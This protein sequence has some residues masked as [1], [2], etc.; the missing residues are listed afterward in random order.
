VSLKTID[1]G[2]C[3]LLSREYEKEKEDKSTGI[4][5]IIPREF[6]ARFMRLHKRIQ[7]VFVRE[8]RSMLAN[9]ALAVDAYDFMARAAIFLQSALPARI[10]RSEIESRQFDNPPF[11]KPRARDLTFTSRHAARRR[12]DA[13][14][15]VCTRVRVPSDDI[16]TLSFAQ[17]KK[18]G[19]GDGR[20]SETPARA[21]E[22]SF[23]GCFPH[24]VQSRGRRRGEKGSY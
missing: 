12:R 2:L 7:C 3:S 13:I 17:G 1:W 21:G 4:L 6:L 20:S 11:K 5:H 19:K 23:R 9:V 10:S 14:L 18:D 24:A 16:A 8:R 15:C 22:S